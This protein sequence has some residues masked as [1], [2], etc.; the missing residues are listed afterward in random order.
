MKEVPVSI[1]YVRRDWLEPSPAGEDERTA[2]TSVGM[3]E[4]TNTPVILTV[5]YV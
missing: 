1:I 5:Q 3:S 2:E 4:F